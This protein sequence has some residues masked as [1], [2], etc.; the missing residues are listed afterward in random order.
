MSD[1]QPLE[2]ISAPFSTIEEAVS[3]MQAIRIVL[4]SEDTAQMVQFSV[5]E[6]S[7]AHLDAR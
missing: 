7:R 4:P 5:S 2:I 1:A 3:K 6:V